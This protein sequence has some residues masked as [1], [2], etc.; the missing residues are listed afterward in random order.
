MSL[1]VDIEKRLGEF[2]LHVEFASEKGI[3]G[4]LG[5]SGCGKS[6]TLRSIA[7]IITPD[8]GRIILNGRTLFDREKHINLSPQKRRVGYLFQNYALF[9]NM[10]VEKNIACGL[11]QEKDKEAKGKAVA[12]MIEKMCL[13]GL[14]KHRPHQLSGGQQQ[15]TALARI[16]AGQPE[17]LLLDEPFSALDNYLKEQLLLELRDILKTFNKDALLV[18]HSRDEAFELCGTLA[19]MENGRIIRMGG[20]REIFADPGTRSGAMLTGCKN[21][22]SAKKAGETLVAVPAWGV[23]FDAGRPVNDELCAIGVR[24]HYFSA[25]IT[26]NAFPVMMVEEIEE[27]FEWTIKFLFA[28]Q[29]AD[30]VPIW[31]RVVKGGRPREIPKALGVAPKDILLLYD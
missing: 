9:P 19:V 6:L 17:M 4:L 20:T 21:I 27:P 18:T 22:V 13:T 3:F 16:L 25:D 26:E 24:A 14:E 29:E 23:T 1:Y 2:L 12:L 31:W 28:V 30:S 7:G 10:T 5:A 8:K 15:R 11:H